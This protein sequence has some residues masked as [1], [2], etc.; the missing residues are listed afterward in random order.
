MSDHSD[1]VRVVMRYA[2]FHDGSDVAVR[3]LESARKQDV[4]V[5]VLEALLE[6]QPAWAKHSG[7]Q[8]DKAWDA[9]AKAGLNVELAQDQISSPEITAVLNQDAADIKTIGVRRTPTFFVDGRP[10]LDFGAEQLKEMVRIQVEASA[11]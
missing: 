6:A 9:A 5:P 10:L 4:F 3:I 8:L 1:K 11:S 7:A 2:A